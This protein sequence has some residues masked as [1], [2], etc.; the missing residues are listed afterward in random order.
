METKLVVIQPS[1]FCNINCRYC[2]LPHRTSSKRIRPE[3]LERIFQDLFAS[4][5]VSD[6]VT[7]VWH[8]GE[9]LVLPIAFYREAFRIQRQYN[10]QD[11]QVFNSFQTNATLITQEW[12]DFFISENIRIG[13]SID[14]PQH[15]HD[16]NRVDRQGRGTFERVM[17]GI[18]LLQKNRIPFTAIA[19]VTD[20]S[21]RY[22][23]D[24]LRFFAKLKPIRLGLN[25]EEV[26]GSNVH[27]SL[28]TETG[29]RLYK[30]FVKCL[31]ELNAQADHPLAI[32]EIDFLM[33]H[34]QSINTHISSETNY[35]TAVLSFD[36]EGNIST[37]S[38]E[39][40][41][42]T[43]PSYGDFF[44]GNIHTQ[45]LEDLLI[46]PKF[47]DVNAKVQSG[48]SRCKQSCEYFQFC[49]GGAPSNKLHENGTFD[50]TETNA[51]RLQI[52]FTTDALLEYLEE[53]HALFA[54]PQIDEE[55]GI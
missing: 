13:V 43:H 53:K 21:A 4:S 39:L 35:P 23:E 11:M 32:R 37:F 14:G 46:H 48:V 24:F 44:F 55:V 2:Y 31:I 15:L 50:S 49:G 36:C 16:R 12:C 1:P 34:I 27:S 47:I 40:L 10:A 51:C 9:P 19:V 25:P 22:P 42:I 28:Y 33:H 3:T 54:D 7:C 29:M 5:W 17:R 6:E 26:E 8:A 41:T 38:P 45:K 52:K 30:Q 20:E 18:A